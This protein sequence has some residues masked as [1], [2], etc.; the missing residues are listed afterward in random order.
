MKLKVGKPP[1]TRIKA[2]VREALK[3]DNDESNKL[4]PYRDYE[5]SWQK[6]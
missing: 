6:G 5:G 4:N 2:P 1:P 3:A